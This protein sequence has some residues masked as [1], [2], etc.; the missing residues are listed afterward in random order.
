MNW[1]NQTSVTTVMNNGT[2]TTRPAKKL[3]R[4]HCIIIQ[5]ES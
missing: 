2:V 3:R 4:S 5:V 1:N